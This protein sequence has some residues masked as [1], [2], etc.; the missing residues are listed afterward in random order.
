MPVTHHDVRR[1]SFLGE[2]IIW[3]G[4]PSVVRTP[5]LFQLASVLALV[6][7]AISLAYGVVIALVLKT[8]PTESIDRK[9]VV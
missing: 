5:P 6:I 4:G 3:E 9:S 1:D 7:A 2:E 8:A